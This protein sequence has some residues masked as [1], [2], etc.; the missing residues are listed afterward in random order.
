MILD[1]EVEGTFTW[2]SGEK[3][4]PNKDISLSHRGFVSNPQIITQLVSFFLEICWSVVWQER[5]RVAGGRVREA[6][7][8]R[9]TGAA[10][11]ERPCWSVP[12]GG[13]E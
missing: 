8:E 12:A 3:L 5:V 13:V 4:Q 9:R 7:L 1:P 10:V 11:L 2:F 6:V